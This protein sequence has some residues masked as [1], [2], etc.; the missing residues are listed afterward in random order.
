MSEAEA[1]L[2]GA[3]H[4]S[5][6]DISDSGVVLSGGSEA[7]T[8]AGMS[9]AEQEASSS[10]EEVVLSDMSMSEA[11][12]V[13]SVSEAEQEASS[14]EEE[15]VFSDTSS[16]R[17][18]TPSSASSEELLDTASGQV[19]GFNLHQGKFDICELEHQL[20]TLL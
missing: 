12:T 6:A 14:S 20:Y 16:E 1:H 9:E 13:A 7:E 17:E 10:E 2:T 11:E 18:G 8:D 3:R 19:L 4:P 5:D 15:V